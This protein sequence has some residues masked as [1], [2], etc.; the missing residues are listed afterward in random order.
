MRAEARR[1]REPLPKRIENKPEL[2]LGSA[3]YLNA[4][5]ELDSERDRGR[6]QRINRSMCFAYATDYD[7]SEEQ[8]DDLWFFIQK[9]DTEFL[10]WW[11][12]RQPKTK[13]PREPKGKKGGR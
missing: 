13:A 9:M 3:L 10:E 6:Y 8:R 5:F 11:Q 4:W 12:R 2:F 1:F 7:L